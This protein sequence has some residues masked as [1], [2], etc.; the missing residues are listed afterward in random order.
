MLSH[1]SVCVNESKCIF[2]FN[3]TGLVQNCGNS[4]VSGIGLD[5]GWDN[6]VLH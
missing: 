3:I 1:V 4:H 5:N 6:I 2:N